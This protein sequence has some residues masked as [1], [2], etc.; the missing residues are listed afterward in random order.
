MSFFSRSFVLGVEEL[1]SFN[2]WSASGFRAGSELVFSKCNLFFAFRAYLLLRLAFSS[3]ISCFVSFDLC[4]FFD[5]LHICCCSI[6]SLLV[7][8]LV[9][10]PLL[11]IFLILSLTE[12][13]YFCLCSSDIFFLRNLLLAASFFL[14]D[15]YSSMLAFRAALFL[16][17]LF[18]STSLSFYSLRGRPRS[19][20]CQP[21]TKSITS[22]AG[23]L[24]IRVSR[25]FHPEIIYITCNEI[26]LSVHLENRCN[27]KPRFSLS[28]CV[29][30]T[31]TRLW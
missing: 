6:L 22:C 17:Y 12:S 23:L 4:F 18:F 5:S 16:M 20:W 31:S 7:S 29:L 10:A 2:I 13:L 26:F 8:L 1:M 30:V 27:W 3:S 11:L 9:V 25:G 15:S 28:C 14:Y 19:I 24:I 21:H